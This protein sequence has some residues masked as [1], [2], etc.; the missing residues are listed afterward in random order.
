MTLGF[1]A[2]ENLKRSIV[3][4]LLRRNPDLDIVRVQDVGLR[5]ADD[6]SILEWAAQERRIVLTHD[7]KTMTSF[8]YER[9]RRGQPMLGILEI[10]DTMPIGQAVEEILVVAECSDEGEW[11]GQ[12]GY[13]PL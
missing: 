1:V 12:V 8:A 10:P 4:G 13:L 9:V 11:Q 6:P 5:T 3:R 7:V 2:D